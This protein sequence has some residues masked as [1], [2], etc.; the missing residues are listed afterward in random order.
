MPLEAK[1][2][3]LI[4]NRGQKGYFRVHYEASNILK[5]A[6]LL[7]HNHTALEATERAQ[8]II[9]ASPIPGNVNPGM[10]LLSNPECKPSEVAA[11]W[12]MMAYLKKERNMLPLKVALDIFSTM[13][14]LKTKS[15]SPLFMLQGFDIFL[16]KFTSWIVSLVDPYFLG[17]EWN[18]FGTSEEQALVHE[19]MLW[20]ACNTLKLPAC[21]EFCQKQFF[22]WMDRPADSIPFHPRGRRTVLIV[23]LTT[24]NTRIDESQKFIDGM[25]QKANETKKKLKGSYYTSTFLGDL[26]SFL[27]GNKN[28]KKSST[29]KESAKPGGIFHSL[30]YYKY[31]HVSP[32]QALNILENGLDQIYEEYG[33]GEVEEFIKYLL[34][35]IVSKGSLKR[36]E[37]IRKKIGLRTSDKS[38]KET[39]AINQEHHNVQIDTTMPLMTM[40]LLRIQSFQKCLPTIVK[41]IDP[42]L[43]NFK[44]NK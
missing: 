10:D 3:A 27:D 44:E 5:V 6:K 9:D 7:V 38:D 39:K 28:I 17:R 41:A 29:S 16:E 1:D 32:E 23:A 33:R 30:V 18:D 11:W 42:L 19:Q 37:N 14:V 21:I 22:A 25:Y 43:T 24:I 13:L 2:E 4:C 20:F 35:P 8:L 26:K 40:H 15:E 31:V 12:K 34:K 36:L